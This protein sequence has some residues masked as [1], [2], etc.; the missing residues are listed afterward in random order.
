MRELYRHDGEGLGSAGLSEA[1]QACKAND[2]AEFMGACEAHGIG[3]AVRYD[4]RPS[5]RYADELARAV[6]GLCASAAD[7]SQPLELITRT[8]TWCIRPKPKQDAAGAFAVLGLGLDSIT[9]RSQ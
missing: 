8:E 1:H 3:F 4:E 7:L 9:A 6:R 5:T 2:H